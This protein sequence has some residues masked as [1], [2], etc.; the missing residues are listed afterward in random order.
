[1]MKSILDD[2]D[3]NGYPSCYVCGTP[4]CAYCV[5]S[6]RRPPPGKPVFPFLEH[7]EVPENAQPIAND[8]VLSCELCAKTLQFQWKNY[9]D[10]KVPLVKRI[11]WLK[12]EDGM[13]YS[14]VEMGVQT[15]YASQ[16]LGLAPDPATVD[17]RMSMN[18]DKPSRTVLNNHSDISR[19]ISSV[20]ISNTSNVSPLP[21]SLTLQS[22]I[23]HPVI[24]QL[25]KK[26]QSPHEISPAPTS[27]PPTTLSVTFSKQY[28]SN[29]NL[30]KNK[31]PNKPDSFTPE[32]QEEALDLT[33]GRTQIVAK[34]VTAPLVTHPPEV[35]DLSMP[36]K[37]ASTEV[38]YVCG[39]HF[40]R[41]SLVEM[42]AKEQLPNHPFFP[43][44]MYHPRPS[45]SH[46]MEASGCVQGCKTCLQLLYNQWLFFNTK[47]IDHKN[48]EYLL[49]KQTKCMD[50][51]YSV[52]CFEC[53]DFSDIKSVQVLFSSNP[54]CKSYILDIEKRQ[55]FSE[56]Q[57]P[58]LTAKIICFDCCQK[59]NVDASSEGSNE[60]IDICETS[61][62][63]LRLKQT[64]RSTTPTNTSAI[65][66]S[67]LPVPK[68]I[69]PELVDENSISC[70]LCH[71]VH[72]K[73]CMYWVAM[74]PESA[75]S[76]CLYFPFVKNVHRVSTGVV[77]DDGRVLICS[78]C[79]QHLKRQWED[80][81]QKSIAIEGRFFSFRVPSVGSS[82]PAHT[83]NMSPPFFT[84]DSQ[85][86]SD[87]F[88]LNKNELDKRYNHGL[89]FE[90]LMDLE[91]D[92]TKEPRSSYVL[93][94]IISQ[95]P[96][97]IQTKCFVCAQ[98]SKP[99]ETYLICSKKQG[100]SP[101]NFPFL[102]T[103][104]T[105]FPQGSVGNNYFLTCTFCFHTLVLQ[106]QRYEKH[107]VDQCGRIYDTYKVP[108]YVCGLKTYRRRLK[109][110][111][112]EVCCLKL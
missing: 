82:S 108:C 68:T 42:F 47:E 41:G 21:Q 109:K 15:E 46:P 88:S 14:G 60:T 102:E 79:Y 72:A 103:H 29:H 8:R 20:A 106:W 112:V 111:Y 59:K 12:R 16:F 49:G 91:V 3:E 23:H 85:N 104:A 39:D 63:E 2:N 65:D 70:Y 69:R 90:S 22:Q 73:N 98:E 89:S 99:G 24:M 83:P 37:N 71:Q 31:I 84:S 105:N 30:Y 80:Y 6:V 97:N 56:G 17:E 13:S 40:T 1:M 9:E 75:S 48:R 87:S 10:S 27:T 77:S 93:S 86:T 26:P 57:P 32:P 4:G 61:S 45:K 33:V 43:S 25:P 5:L 110:L 36:D 66:D 54:D 67:I 101:I 76:D 34:C 78:P 44:L 50:N 92:L 95:N 58:T 19:Q 38:C 94:P 74:F 62:P 35:L 11:Y 100:I 107:N 18:S 28:H 7:H 52:I 96:L 55:S 53:H 81:E 64:C 51:D